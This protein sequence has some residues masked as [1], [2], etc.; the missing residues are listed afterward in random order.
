MGKKRKAFSRTLPSARYPGVPPVG[1]ARLKLSAV[2]AST[3]SLAG[4]CDIS[5]MGLAYCFYFFQEV[6]W[7]PP[8]GGNIRPTLAPDPEQPS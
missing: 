7:N 1:C 3:L 4:V 8:S 6:G 5:H 2:P